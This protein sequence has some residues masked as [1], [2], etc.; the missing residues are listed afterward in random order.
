M[1]GANRENPNFGASDSNKNKY[2]RRANTRASRRSVGTIND[3]SESE[4]KQHADEDIIN[5]DNLTRKQ[6]KA[7]PQLK[8]DVSYGQYLHMPKSHRA[9]FTSQATK[10]RNRMILRWVIIVALVVIIYLIIKSFM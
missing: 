10:Y 3:W 9:I 5:P 1:D 6:L 8:H 2:S 7:M 4:S